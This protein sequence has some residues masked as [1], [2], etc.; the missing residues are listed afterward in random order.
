M[1]EVG[2]PA[3][4][5]HG[6]FEADV[7]GLRAFLDLREQ[8][9][10]SDLV[11]DGFLIPTRDLTAPT[12]LFSGIRHRPGLNAQVITDLRGRVIDW[13]HQVLPGSV[14]DAKAFKASGLAKAYEIHLTGDGP[15]LIGDLGYLGVV[16]LTP[17]RKPEY[18]DLTVTEGLFN[19]HVNQRRCVVEQGISHLRSWKILTTGYRRPLRKPT[20][21]YRQ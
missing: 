14:H 7:G 18:R 4:V 2:L 9:L 21:Q 6:G 15:S 13:G 10:R 8:A 3:F 16:P 11:V 17:Y 12:G 1:G 5:G 20:K 19:R